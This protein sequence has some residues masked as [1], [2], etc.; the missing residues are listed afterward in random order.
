M[1]PM[2]SRIQTMSGQEGEPARDGVHGDG[3]ADPAGHHHQA[4]GDEVGVDVDCC[5]PL[6]SH[7]E[8]ISC[9]DPAI[10]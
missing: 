7:A 5:L 10:A 9:F 1:N 3:E 4:A 6:H 8:S 2:L